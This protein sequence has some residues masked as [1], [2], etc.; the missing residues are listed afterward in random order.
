MTVSVEKASNG[1]ILRDDET[2]EV[3]VFQKEY[4][5]CNVALAAIL[6]HIRQK[7]EDPNENI[8]T[9]FDITGSLQ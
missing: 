8:R 4:E 3:L 9:V 6:N 5:S 1:Y 7:F 2:D